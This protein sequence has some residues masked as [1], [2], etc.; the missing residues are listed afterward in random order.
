MGK[1]LELGERQNGETQTSFTWVDM[2][3]LIMDVY[4]TQRGYAGGSVTMREAVCGLALWCLQLCLGAVWK[5]KL[6]F[7]MYVILDA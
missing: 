6:T 4:S 5:R 1:S 2:G 7:Q 3:Q